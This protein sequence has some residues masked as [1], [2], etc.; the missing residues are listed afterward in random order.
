M[1]HGSGKPHPCAHQW[2]AV[3]CHESAARLCNN[4]TAGCLRHKRASVDKCFHHRNSKLWH[5]RRREGRVGKDRREGGE[6]NTKFRSVSGT[7]CDVEP[8]VEGTNS[9]DESLR[10]CRADTW[11]EPV[12]LCG[13][14]VV[15]FDALLRSTSTLYKQTDLL[16]GKF[17]S[18]F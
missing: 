17:L 10:T 7:L 13:A 5:G 1:H 6:E 14:I 11:V 16:V 15:V 3:I 12:R 18:A 9:R 2:G 4:D 8:P